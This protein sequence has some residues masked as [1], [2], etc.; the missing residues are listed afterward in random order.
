MIVCVCVA[1]ILTGTK[2]PGKPGRPVV[3]KVSDREVSMDWVPPDSDGGSQIIQYIIYHGSS[4]LDLESSVKLEIVGRSK[5]CTFSKRLTFNK[6]YK[7]AVAAK[8]KRG[9]GPLSDFSDCIKTP[10]RG[11]RHDIFLYGCMITGLLWNV[12][13]LVV[14]L[15]ENNS[16]SGYITISYIKMN[17]HL[18]I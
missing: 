17:I 16:Q 6:T 10:T 18:H 2:V 8:N 1:Y 4:D 13:V 15:L 12:V 9:V 5:L 3:N 14:G 11:G 7:F